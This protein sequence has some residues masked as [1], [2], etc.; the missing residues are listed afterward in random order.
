MWVCTG[1][2]AFA[3]G[4]RL[5]AISL[6]AGTLYS[7]AAFS[8]AAA[9]SGASTSPSAGDLVNFPDDRVRRLGLLCHAGS[10]G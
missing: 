4:H 9:S 6:L 5:N 7:A 8:I 10:V 3:V 1:D 2:F